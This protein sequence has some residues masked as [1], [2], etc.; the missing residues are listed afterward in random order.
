MPKE[1][2]TLEGLPELERALATKA[3]ELAASAAI[4][5]AEEVKLIEADARDGAPEGPTGDLRGSIEGES[6]GTRGTI[7]APIRYAG[8]VEHGTYKDAAQPFMKPA[9]ERARRRF[10]QRAAD[11]IRAALG[12]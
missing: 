4:A 3:A 2:V 1:L 6:D 8:F 9:A 10:P 11:I 5:V 12:G 7:K